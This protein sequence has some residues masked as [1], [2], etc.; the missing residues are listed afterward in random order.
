MLR[1]LVGPAEAHPSCVR[2]SVERV[3]ADPETLTIRYEW[4][5]QTDLIKYVRDHDRR[6]LIEAV[7]LSSKVPEI[8]LET[9]SMIL[10]GI[11]VL[12]ELD[13]G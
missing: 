13:N 11:E 10:K 8:R 12:A 5:N 9:V 2:C 4:S 7:D 3:P 1:S 6:V